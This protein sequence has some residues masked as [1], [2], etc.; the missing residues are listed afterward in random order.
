MSDD[1]VSPSSVE[2]YDGK[3][4]NMTPPSEDMDGL[5]QRV[6]TQASQQM[7]LG[8]QVSSSST[9]DVKGVLLVHAPFV[10]VFF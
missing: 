3:E 5:R 10:A 9:S 1:L 7:K 2:V 4:A 8:E 6:A